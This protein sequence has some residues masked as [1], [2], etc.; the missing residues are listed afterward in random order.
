[1]KVDFKLMQ[2]EIEQD[3]KV[4]IAFLKAEIKNTL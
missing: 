1:M 4:Q 2:G 3:L